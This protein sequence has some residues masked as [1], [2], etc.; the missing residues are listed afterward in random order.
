MASRSKQTEIQSPQATRRGT[1]GGVAVEAE[2]V[3][4]YKYSAVD[5]QIIL[6]IR[7]HVTVVYPIYPSLF[8]FQPEH[9]LE[10]SSLLTLLVWIWRWRWTLFCLF[11]EAIYE[12]ACTSLCGVSDLY[13]HFHKWL[14]EVNKQR[15]TPQTTI[16]GSDRRG[17]GRGRVCSLL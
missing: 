12:R 1:I 3:H 17:S 7:W 5:P 13:T 10:V 14:P 9:S 8:T 16:R 2:F 4:C 15:F 11:R 6:C